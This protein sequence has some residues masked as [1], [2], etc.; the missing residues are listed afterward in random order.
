MQPALVAL[1]SALWLREPPTRRQWL[2]IGIAVAGACV[3]AL[4][5]ILSTP[6]A[7]TGRALLGDGL[8]L[9]GAATA[10]CYFVAGRRLR[11][12]LDI[13]PYVGLVYGTCF[14]MLIVFA[15][16]VRAPVLHQPPRELAIFL[17]LAIGPML[18][19]HTGLN[20][21]LKYLPAYVVNLTLLGEPIGATLLAAIIP[22]IREVPGVATFVGGAMIVAGVYVTTRRQRSG[23]PRGPAL[24]R[25][26]GQARD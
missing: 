2:G 14:V 12:T 6:T 24:A 11:A 3:V 7:L 19:G 25:I 16:S 17:A 4:P 20:W 18:L 21:A 13:W 15:A 26:S 9:A 23:R 10:A 8:A 22:S 5:D 1:L